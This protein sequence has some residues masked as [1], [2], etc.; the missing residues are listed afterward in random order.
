[1]NWYI[2]LYVYNMYLFILQVSEQAL[3]IGTVQMMCMKGKLYSHD[4]W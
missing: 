3:P 2:G 1:M 4:I